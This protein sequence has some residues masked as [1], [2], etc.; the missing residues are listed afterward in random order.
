MTS[1]HISGA[2]YRITGHDTKEDTR[3]WVD[4]DQEWCLLILS[5]H[6]D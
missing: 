1:V 5:S 2:L 3:A 6:C 4:M